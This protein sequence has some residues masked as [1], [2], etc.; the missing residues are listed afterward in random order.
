MWANEMLEQLTAQ[1]ARDEGVTE[2]LKAN[3][4]M[5]WVRRMNSIHNRA[6]ENVNSELI[7]C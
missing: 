6:E 5:V 4:Q 2:Q 7:F 1:M 3:N